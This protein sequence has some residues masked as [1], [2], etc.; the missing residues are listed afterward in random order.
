CEATC[1][2]GA[3]THNDDNYVVD[4]DKCNFCMDC[5][6][7]CPTGSIDNWRLVPRA[8]A[9]TV[10]EQFGWEELPAELTPEQLAEAGVAAGMDADAAG[11]DGTGGSGGIGGEGPTGA[12]A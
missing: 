3:I 12:S 7:P 6:S 4:A 8:N 10:E 5:I 2:V 11:S 9:Y 1:P